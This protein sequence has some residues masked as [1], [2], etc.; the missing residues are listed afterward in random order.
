MP[1]WVLVW[2]SNESNWFGA[3]YVLSQRT[4]SNRTKKLNHM[5]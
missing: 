1:G 2:V 3:N 4:W 5:Q